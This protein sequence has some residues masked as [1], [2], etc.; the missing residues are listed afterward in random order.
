MKIHTQ[1][2]LGRY[3]QVLA[4]GG[5]LLLVA[6]LVIDTRWISH[7]ISTAVL[8]V[9]IFAL[10]SVPVRLSKY[11]YL[12]QSA[13]PTL[14]GAVCVGPA[15]VVAA[16]WVGVAAADVFGLRKP[17]RAGLINAGRE[18]IGF[19]ASY[20]PYAAILAIGT[21]SQHTLDFLPAAAIL[22]ALY[23][24]LTRALF[25]FSLMIRNK[26]ES[27]EKILI[28]RWEIS[29]Y[30]L[31]LMAVTLVIWTLANM[32]PV[33]W[34]AVA[35]V[36]G[37]V[38]LLARHILD[39]AIGAEDL[40]KVHLMESA[41]ASNATL[42][43]SFTQIERLAYRL[44]D[45][46]DFR[47]YRVTPSGTALAYRAAGGRPDRGEPPGAL[48]ALR[49]E[50][51]EAREPLMI[52]DVRHDP[53]IADVM[54][55][56]LTLV[57]HPIRFGED[58]L[59]LLEVEHHKRH[60][61]GSKDLMAMSTLAAQM[62]TAI[63]I[64]E[65][66]R[67]LV[68]TVSQI[69][70]QVTALARVADSL[71]SSASALADVSLGMR[72]GALELERFATGGLRA[73]GSLASASQEMITQGAQAAAAS[74]TAAEVAAR[75]RDVIGDAI[76]RLVELK[77]FVAAGADR[78][79]TLGSMTQRITGF[80]GTIREIA[81]LTNLIALNA[82]IEAA[83]AG[84]EGRGF[85]VVASEVRDLAAQ[86]LHAAGE[87][88]T[89]LGEIADQVSAVSGQ[90]DRGRDV[91][92][93]VEELSANA[94]KALD[95][96]VGTTGEAGGHAQAIAVTAAQQREAVDTLTG[97]IERVAASSAKSRADTDTLAKR[98]GEA[99][100]GQA[101]LERAIRGLGEL[102]T[103]LQR[104]ASHFAVEA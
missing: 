35:L 68:L 26:L 1:R 70:E 33:G 29:S 59:G 69:G 77:G 100:A 10:R 89:L 17:P 12:T 6:A 4:V 98:A 97:Q 42:Q 25:Y 34:V 102:A 94:A 101:E 95:A 81:D 24:F 104:I 8:M 9:S 32:A 57:I 62:A 30:L 13:V 18:V 82:A 52:R 72:Q 48:Q 55:N 60:A 45:W 78:V 80:I 76:T 20:G 23:F 2:L 71:R 87:A 64:A 85:A 75:N 73:T 31:T 11:S 86:S 22:V 91:V 58:I 54:R 96:I 28:L 14:V 88:S 43:G 53:R 49:Q 50:V 63:H 67:P 5:L 56:V 99:S 16:L 83:R 36:L 3:T 27:A 40:N 79:A 15:P 84:R 74:G 19:V 65:L 21:T 66:R 44:L 41:I 38:G 7:P 37:V 61:Y 90:M 46:G 103:D 47:V 39:E 51:L 92:A 93:G